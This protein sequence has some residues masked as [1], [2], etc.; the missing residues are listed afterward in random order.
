MIFLLI[1]VMIFSQF[2]SRSTN[3]QAQETEDNGLSLS[4]SVLGTEVA[5][6]I[7]NSSM[8]VPEL[9]S[10]EKEK[11]S[12]GSGI[13][14]MQSIQRDT[15][16]HRSNNPVNGNNH[17]TNLNNASSRDYERDLSYDR[18]L[19]GARESTRNL[20]NVGSIGGNDLR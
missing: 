2:R 1:S 4:Y 9:S 17:R 18:E 10:R 8:Y 16:S 20:M 12:T 19:N 13:T 3:N 11:A 7:A 14:G 15:N 6:R 5:K